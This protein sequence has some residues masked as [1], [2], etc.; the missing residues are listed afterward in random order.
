MFLKNIKAQNTA[1]S[2][3]KENILLN[4]RHSFKIAN[5]IFCV[6]F[7]LYNLNN[8]YLNIRNTSSKHKKLKTNIFLLL[9]EQTFKNYLYKSQ[10]SIPIIILHLH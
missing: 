1:K 2:F 4:L 10:L 5:F 8:V 6:Q 9:A 3:S 7:Q